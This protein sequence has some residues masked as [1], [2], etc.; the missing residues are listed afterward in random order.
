MRVLAFVEALG[1]TG[2]AR[3]LFALAP[4]VDLHLATFRRLSLGS[5][6]CAGV[7]AFASAARVHGV[8]VRV[9]DE[10]SRFDWRVLDGIVKLVGGVAPDVV[11]S[12]HLKS[13]ALLAL[14]RRRL[15]VSW[16]SWHHGY[17]RTDLKV[18]A[19][20]HVDRWSLPKADLVLTTC[21]PF[22]RELARYG[23]AADRLCVVHNAVAPPRSIA[24]TW[25]RAQLGLGNQT[26]ILS[27]GRL[28][29]EKG[30]DVL[31]EACARVTGPLRDRLLLLFVG[32]GPERSRLE[33]LARRRGVAARFDGHRLDLS[34]Y[35]T[36]ADVF[37][38]PSRSEGSPN[39]LLEAMAA[40]KP[41]AASA[42]GGV[43]EIVDAKSAM[44]V[45]PEDPVALAAAVVRLI[46][47]PDLAQ[48]LGAAARFASARFSPGARAA[49]ILEIYGRIPEPIARHVAR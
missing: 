34:A 27:V 14:A 37:A 43:P 42:V 32:S 36:A 9:I 30:H 3:N 2:P 16:V 1:V 6:H 21:E 7:D 25:A 48:R 47:F 23:I 8:P 39:A 35:Y 4:Y 12:H 15:D 38:L 44:L 24:R 40:G 5:A 41:I 20:N 29:R 28:S 13:H 10:R 26:A 22:S 18:L 17:T 46:G 33:R 19:Y 49:R 11:E 31:I 45:P